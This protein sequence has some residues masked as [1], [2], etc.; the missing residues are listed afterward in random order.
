[1][2]HDRPEVT[3]D[4][5]VRQAVRVM[6]EAQI[7]A[8]AVKEGTTVVGVFTER[9]LMKRVVAA[10]LDPDA[11]PI[12]Q[13]MTT[14]VVTVLDSTSVVSAAAAMRAHHMS[15]LVIVDRAGNYLGMLAQRHVLYDWMN[16]LEAKVGDLTSYVMTDG[17]GG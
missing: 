11:T 4:V 10:G 14:N 9:D 5:S 7:G 16:D 2:T 12:R 17:P 15:H 8:I 3:P 13:V 6:V 1:L